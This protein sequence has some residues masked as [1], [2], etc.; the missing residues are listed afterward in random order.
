MVVIMWQYI[1]SMPGWFDI[2]PTP[3]AIKDD[4]QIKCALLCCGFPSYLQPCVVT[5]HFAI[6]WG[7]GI[8]QCVRVLK[9]LS[10]T[11]AG[12]AEANII[13]LTLLTFQRLDAKLL[14]AWH[15]A[16][17][18]SWSA[19]ISALL[20]VSVN[21]DRDNTGVCLNINSCRLIEKHTYKLWV[22]GNNFRLRKI[23]YCILSFNLLTSGALT[24]ISV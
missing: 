15:S 22:F 12:H 2:V 5:R 10:L 6:R 20:K 23:I 4:I 8:P 1:L 24:S 13:M 3:H 16:N 18:S 7:C 9:P 14:R 17:R 21:I 19:I 11:W